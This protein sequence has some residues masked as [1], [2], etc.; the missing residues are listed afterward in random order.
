MADVPIIVE[1]IGFKKMND[2]TYH[3]LTRHIKITPFAKGDL[4]KSEYEFV[5]SFCERLGPV[6]DIIMLTGYIHVKFTNSVE[7]IE[8]RIMVLRG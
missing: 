7:D 5:K 3:L 2:I 8:P 6:D 1:C 4:H